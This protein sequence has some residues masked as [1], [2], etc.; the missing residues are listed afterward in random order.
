MDSETAA[1][2]FTLSFSLNFLHTFCK[3]QQAKSRENE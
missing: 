3:Q 2:T 1:K